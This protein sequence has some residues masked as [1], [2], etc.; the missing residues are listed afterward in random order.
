MSNINGLIFD[1]KRFAVHDGPGIRTTIFLKGCPLSC[2]WCHN[3]EGLSNSQEIIYYDYK[4]M[5]CDKC[6]NI[7]QQNALEEKNNKIVRNH[8]ICTSCGNC[9]EICPTA[10]QQIIGQ[11]ISAENTIKEIEKDRI[12]FE[13][14]NGGV[15]FSGGEPLMQHEFLKETLKLCKK[16]SIHTALDTSGFCHSDVFNTLIKF[17]DL[18]LYD[19]KI[20]DDQQ[21][22]KY[23]GV[24]NK[25]IIKNLD[26]LQEKEKDIIIRFTIVKGITDTKENLRDIINLVSSFEKIKGID[27]LPFHNVNEKY[28]RIGKQN[29]LKDIKPPS[30]NDIKRIKKQFEQK[31]LNVRISG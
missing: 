31:D 23:T 2:W 7:C 9:V 18:F 14:S 28:Q 25:K 3:P 16:R 17:N 1:I 12:F 6:I 11:K 13:T 5:N 15:T 8:K 20:I 4:C 19:L 21:H 27:L 22:K 29:K 24:S 26:I 10:S 30:S